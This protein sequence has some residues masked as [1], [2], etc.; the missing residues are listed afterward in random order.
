[1]RPS[2][3]D[4]YVKAADLGEFLVPK[5]KPSIQMS[6]VLPRG[7]VDRLGSTL[8]IGRYQ[9][10]MVDQL[11]WVTA[12]SGRSTYMGPGMHRVYL[13]VMAELE[14]SRDLSS[15]VIA[16]LAGVSQGYAS[17]VIRWL[18]KFRFI[19]ILGVFR[20][21]WGRIVAK[22]VSI[23]PTVRRG[24]PV[25]GGM[26]TSEPRYFTDHSVPGDGFDAFWRSVKRTHPD[27]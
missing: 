9:P 16:N 15:T 2:T 13:A 11:V 14:A 8:L 20:G 1:M 24:S 6:H 17:K 7:T 4:Q 26:I 5:V 23:I 10:K 27:G 18:E 19:T 22:L 3:V 12:P 25:Y 21:R